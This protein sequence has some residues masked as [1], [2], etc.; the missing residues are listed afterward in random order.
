M[1]NAKIS[2]LPA[3]TSAAGGDLAVAVASSVTSQITVDNLFKNRT[4]VAPALG[5]ATATS[6]NKVAITAPA[7]S[8]TLTI[9]DGKTATVSNTLTFSGTDSSSVAFGTGGTVAYTG[10][11]LSVFAATTSSQL[12]GVISDETGSGSLVFAT[13]P[14]LV[15]PTLGVAAATSV[16]KVAITAP[17]TA[18][19]LTI[20]DGKTL[21]TN[22]TLTLA[23]TDST[24]MTFPTTSATLARTDA[25]NS[26]TGNQ[27]IGGAVI[28]TPGTRT[29]PGAVDVT[30][31]TTAFTSTGAADA[32]TLADGTTGQ[33]KTVVY[34]A[35]GAGGDSGELVPTNR[36]GY[37]KITFN[38]IGDS[39]TLQF[40]GTGWAI[41]ALYGAVK[42]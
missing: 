12:A 13:S 35:E 34:V 18:A 25:A 5:A 36:I 28:T 1:A 27:T 41:L 33:I 21:T 14:T 7:T 11:N 37:A 32:L 39:A 38:D 26:F 29:G 42:S 4:L 3:V 30:T 17:A 6:V 20:A 22:N 31:T 8:A 10:N 16:N 23:G 40:V 24:T 19:T 9:A 2:Q 15:T